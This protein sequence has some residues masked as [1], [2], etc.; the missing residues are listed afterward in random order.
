MT[1]SIQTAHNV[2][3]EYAVASVADRILAVLVD[4]L[5][6]IAYVFMMIFLLHY[7]PN[8]IT[9]E[10]WVL[11]IILYLPIMFYELVS[12]IVLEGQTFGKKALNIKVIQL[13]GSQPSISSFII[14]WLIRL[15]EVSSFG[16]AVALLAL[17]VSSK[18]QRIGDVAANTTVVKLRALNKVLRPTISEIEDKD[19]Y[20]PMFP[21]ALKLTDKDV[22]VARE[23]LVSYRQ[24]NN[25]EL[26][27]TM[28]YRLREL[29]GIH[30]TALND[31]DF[32]RQLIKDYDNLTAHS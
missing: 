18:G 12:E 27:K 1:I 17:F 5:V 9:N 14:R 25:T 10:F 32:L 11:I 20:L 3:I 2:T 21:E 30:H 13:D 24:T 8:F 26:V 7:F 22:N 15:I 28:N 4:G 31:V 16:G 19:S 23:V 6:Q 29:L